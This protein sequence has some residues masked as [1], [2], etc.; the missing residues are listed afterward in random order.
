MQKKQQKGLPRYQYS[1]IFDLFYFVSYKASNRKT[2][3]GNS[4][5]ERMVDGL[6]VRNSEVE[7]DVL[8]QKELNDT[9]KKTR[10]LKLEARET[11]IR[12]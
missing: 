11:Y 2:E 6:E 1:H 10:E 5:R 3:G 9:I 8:K 7:A 4:N 12:V